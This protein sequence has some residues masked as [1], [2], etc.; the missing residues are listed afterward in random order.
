MSTWNLELPEFLFLKLILIKINVE[1]IKAQDKQATFV[2]FS[3]SK[4]L[5]DTI[6]S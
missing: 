1:Q 5:S 4:V 6:H 3:G 2:H